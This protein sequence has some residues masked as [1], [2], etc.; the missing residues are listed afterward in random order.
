MSDTEH[1]AKL[2]SFLAGEFARQNHQAVIK[3]ELVYAPGSGYRADP[4]GSWTPDDGKSA[5][6]FSDR[7]HVFVERLVGEIIELA[8]GHAES[9]GQGRHRFTVHAYHHLSSRTHH[10]FVI[11]PSFDGDDQALAQAQLADPSQANLVGQLM[12]HIENRDRGMREMMGTFLQTMSH[13]VNAMRAESDAKQETI[14]TLLTERLEYLQ[15]IEEANS[16]EHE[17]QIEALV[18]TG[19]KERKDLAVKKVFGLLPVAVSQGLSHL[20][21]SQKGAGGE[22]VEKE[23]SPLAKLALRLMQS[24]KTKQRDLIEDTLGIEQRIMLAEAARVAG[25]GGSLVLPS[26]LHELASSLSSPQIAAIMG[27][28]EHEQAAMFVQIIQVSKAQADPEPAK[29]TAEDPAAANG[30]EVTS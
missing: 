12:R 19:D 16:K 8:E 1:H 7:G 13:S 30:T 6:L 9:Y 17:R 23:P 3:I 25:E 24:L 2:L 29:P 26:L 21:K 10:A 11:K 5:E 15:K 27:C 20:K 22:D 4:L 14:N 18:V 28:L